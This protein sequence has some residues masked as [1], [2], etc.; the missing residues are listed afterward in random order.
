MQ[1]A[2]GQ[3]RDQV[4]R[5]YINKECRSSRCDSKRPYS[6]SSSQ[7]LQ[8]S[9]FLPHELRR[10]GDQVLAALQLGK[11][12]SRGRLNAIAP[13]PLVHI[14][15]QFTKWPWWIWVPAFLSTLTLQKLHQRGLLYSFLLASSSLV[16]GAKSVSLQFNNKIFTWT[17]L[18]AGV[19]FPI[20]RV[21]F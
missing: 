19:S 7:V 18:L 21:F 2:V 14:E 10:Q 11:L 4:C 13:G 3:R 15:D 20:I 9:L 6:L 1:P 8:W 17:F 12:A 5:S 16:G